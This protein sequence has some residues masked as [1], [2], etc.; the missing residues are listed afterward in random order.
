[1]GPLW[2]K[3]SF[4]TLHVFP[5][6]TQFQNLPGRSIIILGHIP[7]TYIFC[8]FENDDNLYSLFPASFIFYDVQSHLHS[9]RCGDIFLFELEIKKL[10]KQPNSFSFQPLLTSVSVFY[11]CLHISQSE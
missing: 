3:L 6:S 8:N 4:K 11:G 7:T 2:L 9:L 10:L 1:M 5:H